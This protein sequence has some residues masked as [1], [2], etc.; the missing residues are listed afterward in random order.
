MAQR[1]GTAVFA[2]WSVDLLVWSRAGM[3]EIQQSDDG[4]HQS[5]VA[6]VDAGTDGRRYVRLRMI[7]PAD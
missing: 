3:E 1:D 5:I 7:L 4:S 2:E 6:G